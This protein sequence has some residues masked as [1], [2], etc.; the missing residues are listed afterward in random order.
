MS[1]IDTFEKLLTYLRR[2]NVGSRGFNTICNFNS[3]CIELNQ[4]DDQLR[5]LNYS[6]SVDRFQFIDGDLNSS[7]DGSGEAVPAYLMDEV[8]AKIATI[9]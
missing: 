8:L 3:S 9:A 6:S 2:N 7:S 5:F 4:I 1:L